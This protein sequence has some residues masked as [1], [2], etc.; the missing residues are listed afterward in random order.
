[1]LICAHL[2]GDVRRRNKRCEQFGVRENRLLCPD[3]AN[4][5]GGGGAPV[6]QR[7]EPQTA[8]P[9]SAA[10]PAVVPNSQVKPPAAETVINGEV[11]EET[12]R[13]R[14]QL[15]EERAARKRVEQDHASVS[16][17]F[18]R[19][20]DATEA[21]AIPVKPGRV[22]SEPASYRFLRPRG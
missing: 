9:P 5:A 19:F 20:K 17:E 21:R 13:L 3:P 11:T 16:D 1:M 2:V 6:G 12:L 22:T 10:P 14:T 4:S 15:E 18:Q 8:V 7:T